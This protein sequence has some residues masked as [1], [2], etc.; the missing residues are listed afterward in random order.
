M[1]RGRARVLLP[2][3]RERARHEVP[4]SRPIGLSIVLRKQGQNFLKTAGAGPKACYV[5]SPTL[6]ALIEL[7]SVNKI[8]LAVDAQKQRVASEI[9][10]II[11]LQV[12]QVL[13]AS[14]HL[15]V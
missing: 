6:Y 2:R 13:A 8:Q 12:R 14:L 10:Y 3:E 1:V 4:N 5:V 11:S 7:K 9:L 15:G